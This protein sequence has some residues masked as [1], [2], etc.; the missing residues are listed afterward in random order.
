MTEGWFKDGLSRYG[1]PWTSTAHACVGD[2]VYVNGM[3]CHL[4]VL[5][6]ER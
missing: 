2:E 1:V 3:K 4:P 6:L 5:F